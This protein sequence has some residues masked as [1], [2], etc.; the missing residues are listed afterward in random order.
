MLFAPIGAFGAM[1]FTIGK[2]GF[3]S[4]GPLREADRHILADFDFVRA[5]RV[6]RELPG[7]PVSASVKFLS[8]HQRR[9]P[10]GAGD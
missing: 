10:A 2:Y 1:A 9:N 7:W 8:A 6:R 3:A 5:D 4:L